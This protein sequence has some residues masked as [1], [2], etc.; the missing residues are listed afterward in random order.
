[1]RR[2]AFESAFDLLASEPSV[3]AEITVRLDGNTMWQRNTN[4]LL[5]RETNRF[6]VYS[7][8]KSFIAILTFQLCEQ[9]VLDL[10][11]TISSRLPYLFPEWAQ[12]LTIHQLLCHRGGI[13]DY[14]GMSFYKDALV[15]APDTPLP[16]EVVYSTVLAEGPRFKPGEEFAYSNV[17]Y[18]LLRDIL[19]A[20]SKLSF[21]DLLQKH[22]LG[23]LNLSD[24]TSVATRDDMQKFTPGYS[25]M[26][27]P[28]AA[29]V[30]SLYHPGWVYHG[31]VGSTGIDITKFFEAVF[32]GRLVNEKHLDLI[33]KPF[34]LPFTAKHCSP[35]YGRGFLGDPASRWGMALGHNGGGP[36]YSISCYSFPQNRRGILTI[37]AFVDHDTPPV[38]AEDLVFSI[39][40]IIED[41]DN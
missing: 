10:S 4:S 30:R 33:K 14:G 2:S 1:M 40:T 11:D 25:R 6:P 19:E 38:D 3:G 34:A 24:T 7:L 15:K 5:L 28:E 32:S 20:A 26:F 29:D 18:A 21:R 27:S 22:I 17:G 23:P 35:H 41:D 9:G 16:K 31:L 37:A 39:A 8:T 36:G 12:S 13:G